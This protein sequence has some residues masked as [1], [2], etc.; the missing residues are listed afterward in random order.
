[1][2]GATRTVM[3][4]EQEHRPKLEAS[5]PFWVDQVSYWDIHDIDVEPPSTALVKLEQRVLWFIDSLANRH[6]SGSPDPIATGA[7]N[8]LT[9]STSAPRHQHLSRLANRLG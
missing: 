8:D 3:L 5:F 9:P 6:A 4:K 2:V 7:G 1:M